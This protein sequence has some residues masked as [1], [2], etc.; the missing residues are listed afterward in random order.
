MPLLSSAASLALL[1][2]TPATAGGGCHKATNECT[3]CAQCCRDFSKPGLCDKCVHEECT[4][5]PLPLGPVCD[6]A[7]CTCDGVDLALLQAR[8]VLQTPLDTGWAFK[9][10]IC[11]KIPPVSLPSGC[12]SSETEGSAAVL[13]YKPDDPSQCVQVGS[14]GTMTGK[15]D[16]N[17]GIDLTW[18]FKSGKQTWFTLHV[19]GGAERQPGNVMTDANETVFSSSWAALDLPAVPACDLS[20]CHC[21]G[22]DLTSLR[23]YVH[24]TPVDHRNYSF[25]FSIC[26]AIPNAQLPAGCAKFA[27]NAAAV[28]YNPDMHPETDCI[29]VGSLCEPGLNLTCGMSGVRTADGVN[30]VYRLDNGAKLSTFEIDITRSQHPSSASAG[31]KHPI[32]TVKT[33]ARRL[34]EN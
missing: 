28:K 32:N 33:L 11:S 30:V 15:K 23:G 21:D 31:A 14:V 20:T 29:E 6:L 25:K 27:V 1:F 24:T 17:G 13:K 7:A 9:I 5:D 4:S 22:V 12:L 18:G 16:G 10:A 8:G 19:T 3:V 34:H 26:D 2:L